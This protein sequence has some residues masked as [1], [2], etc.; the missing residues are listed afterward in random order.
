PAACSRRWRRG[1]QGRPVGA[2]EGGF[3]RH[4]VQV[5]PGAGPLPGIWNS[6]CGALYRTHNLAL[7][8]SGFAFN[9]LVIFGVGLI[10]GSLARALR[11]R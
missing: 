11:E 1:G 2:A 10:G 6:A 9:K 4:P 7:V 8:V 5:A 3:G